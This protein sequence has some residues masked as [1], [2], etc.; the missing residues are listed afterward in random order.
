MQNNTVSPLGK[1]TGEIANKPTWRI[2]GHRSMNKCHVSN[3]T[4]KPIRSTG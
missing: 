3:Y 4:R 2:P 1:P